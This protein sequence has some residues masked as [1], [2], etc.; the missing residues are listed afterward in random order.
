M[1]SETKPE[2]VRAGALR[3]PALAVLCA[4]AVLLGACV[5]AGPRR[6]AKDRFHYA[7]AIGDTRE[8]QALLNIVKIRYSEFPTFLDLTQ[9]VTNYTVTNQLIVSGLARFPLLDDKSHEAKPV[10]T[11]AMA[12]S[13]SLVYLPVEGP[14]LVQKMLKPTGA[15]AVL[16]LV[17]TGWAADSLLSA[18]AFSVNGQRN[19]EVQ[20]LTPN[21]ADPGFLRFANLARQAQRANALA[22]RLGPPSAE[23]AALRNAAFERA[24][25]APTAAA[26]QAALAALGLPPV[27]LELCFRDRRLSAAALA[28]LDAMRE[29]LG[30]SRDVD[31]Y[32][33]ITADR[34]PDGE[35]LALQMRSMFQLMTELAVFVEVPP[36]DL[37]SG[38]APTLAGREGA[39][40]GGEP[41]LAIR[42]GPE[43]PE[44]ATAA[45]LY[46]GSWFWID[47]DDLASKRTFGS[48]ML[49]LSITE[50]GGTGAQLVVQTN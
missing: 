21:P 20:G 22:I 48:L 31:C 2:L 8:T 30:L 17:R 6:M 14:D 12:E 27:T 26:R 50:S 7:N 28:E 19:R 4:V 42:S 40:A 16:A 9:V 1:T 34:S 49:L 18:L 3:W 38:A 37:A 43:P 15:A 5:T 10:Y 44:N 13:P 36:T 33:V 47:N 24:A 35:T 39:D 45:V 23:D 25:A 29:E 32:A 41:V 46:S 11:I